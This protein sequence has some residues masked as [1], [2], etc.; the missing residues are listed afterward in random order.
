MIFYIATLTNRTGL[1]Y[2]VDNLQVRLTYAV[3][4][5]PLAAPHLTR[6]TSAHRTYD[7]QPKLVLIY[8][9]RIGM[10]GLVT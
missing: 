4:T 7:P 9:P 1:L 2:V 8:Q 3:Y 10:K 6:Y 5:E